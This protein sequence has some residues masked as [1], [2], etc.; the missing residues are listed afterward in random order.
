MRGGL[1]VDECPRPT[2][3]TETAV[4]PLWA[5]PFIFAFPI[6][7]A[8]FERTPM[9]ARRVAPSS[10]GTSNVQ[11]FA[12]RTAPPYGVHSLSISFPHAYH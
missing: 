6:L 2:R 3:A 8:P 7:S 10:R 1:R 4:D 5:T 11:P 9:R 12:Q